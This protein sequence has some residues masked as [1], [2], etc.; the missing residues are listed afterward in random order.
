VDFGSL[1]QMIQYQGLSLELN[2]EALTRTIK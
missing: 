2:F 1:D